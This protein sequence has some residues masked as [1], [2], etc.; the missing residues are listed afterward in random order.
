MIKVEKHKKNVVVTQYSKQILHTFYAS[1]QSS[2][3]EYY[4]FIY[5]KSS[6]AFRIIYK[7]S[8]TFFFFSSRLKL[9]SILT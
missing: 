2:L 8:S 5:V 1:T 9:T 7:S 6:L 3:Y 4:L